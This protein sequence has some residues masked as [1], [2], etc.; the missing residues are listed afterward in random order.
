MLIPSTINAN[1]TITPVNVHM[2]L[3]EVKRLTLGKT[4]ISLLCVESYKGHFWPVH[5]VRFSPDGELYTA[6]GKTYGLWICMLP[7]EGIRC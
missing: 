5:C 2:N 7:G 3:F 4:S 1:P 6:V